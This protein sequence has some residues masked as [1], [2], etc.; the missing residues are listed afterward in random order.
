MVTYTYFSLDF[1]QRHR[2]WKEGKRNKRENW[3]KRENNVGKKRKW[4][5]AREQFVQSNKKR[6][7]FALML[8]AKIHVYK[9]QTRSFPYSCIWKEKAKQSFK[10]PNKLKTTWFY[11]WGGPSENNT[12]G[13]LYIKT[14]RIWSPRRGREK[15]RTKLLRNL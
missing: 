6:K 11:K 8:M 9:I 7:A 2:K 15:G 4:S 5:S 13:C 3:I 12:V 1:P 10:A 14:G